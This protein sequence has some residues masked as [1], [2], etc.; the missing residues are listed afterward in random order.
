MG[1]DHP[2]DTLD[3]ALFGPVMLPL[4]SALLRRATALALDADLSPYTIEESYGLSPLTG[5][6]P[7]ALVHMNRLPE[8]QA[9]VIG[10]VFGYLPEP[11]SGTSRPCP[12]GPGLSAPWITEIPSPMDCGRYPL[13]V[14][15][16]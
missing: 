12:P 15:R 5:V 9:A 7:L 14:H 10:E 2:P 1:D 11:L 4:Y 8:P 6:A 3:Q 13:G 16:L